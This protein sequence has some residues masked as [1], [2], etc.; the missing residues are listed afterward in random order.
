ML[1]QWFMRLAIRRSDAK[2][3]L[4]RIVGSLFLPELQRR[5][6]TNLIELDGSTVNDIMIPRQ[7]VIGIDLD[8]SPE[9]ILQ[10]LKQAVHTRVP[11]YHGNINHTVGI[12]HVRN[13]ARLLGQTQVSA[14]DILQYVRPPYFL[15]ERTSLPTQ[16]VAFQKAKRRLGLV[17]N[18]YGDIQ[19]IITLES[20]L[21]QLVGEFTTHHNPR[22]PEITAV[23]DGSHVIDG[24]TSLRAINRALNWQLPVQSARTLNGLLLSELESIPDGPMCLRIDQYAVEVQQLRGHLVERARIWKITTSPQSPQ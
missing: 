22:S 20:I 16:L 9:M 12:L 23:A 18:E 5:L 11:V 15:P 3:W 1:V 6:L 8:A 4:S 7:A 2:L 14:A 10:S 24:S 13:V 19:G 17:V 21:E